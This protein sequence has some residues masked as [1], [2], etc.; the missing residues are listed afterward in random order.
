MPDQQHFEVGEWAGSAR[1]E[2]SFDVF[3]EALRPFQRLASLPAE[4]DGF[5]GTNR[6]SGRKRTGAETDFEALS[7][8]LAMYRNKAEATQKSYAIEGARVH[9]WAVDKRGKALSS[10]DP[11]DLSAYFDFLAAPSPDWLA[12]GKYKRDDARW[13]PL[14]RPLSPASIRQARTIVSMLFDWLA[15]VGYLDSNPFKDMPKPKRSFEPHPTRFLSNEAVGFLQAHLASMPESTAL[16]ADRKAR[17]KLLGAMFYL[18]AARISE[19]A[20][21]RERDFHQLEDKTWWWGLVGKGGKPAMIP[22]TAELME[23]IAEYR[24]HHGLPAEPSPGN[25]SPL[26][27]RR[28]RQGASTP[29][30]LSANMIHRAVVAIFSAASKAAAAEGKQAIAARLG[31]ATAHWMRHTS[32]THQLASGMDLATVRDNA[33]HSSIATTSRYLWTDDQARHRK[34]RDSLI[35]KKEPP[36]L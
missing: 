26:I 15:G 3:A 13:K 33:R 22:A 24:S 27:L 6:G 36:A 20:A 11:E 34:T 2:Q 35:Y 7:A 8:W 31:Q 12:D 30:P 25:P 21:A 10:L 19:V 17:A 5:R 16:E 14:R 1:V 28:A 32:L 9:L 29:L 18:T 4:L 23:A